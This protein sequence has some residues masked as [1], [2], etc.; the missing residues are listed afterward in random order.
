[1]AITFF[2]NYA[3]DGMDGKQ[4]RRTGTSGAT[5][6]FFD[7]GIDTCITVPL[8]ITLFS[9]VGRGEFSTPFVRVMYVLLSVQ[10]YVHAIHWEQ[11]NTGVMRSPWGYNIGNWMLMGTYLMTYIIG[12]E[13]YKTYVFGL[14][15]PVILLE[16]GFYS[17]H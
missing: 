6:E 16:T 7:H 15:R 12:C 11:Y 17:S 1:M 8:A 14:I 9:S 10:I 2:A 3:L 13:S 4:A 5:G